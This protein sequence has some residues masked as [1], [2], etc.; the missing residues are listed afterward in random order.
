MFVYQTKDLIHPLAAIARGV[1]H[2]IVI[3]FGVWNKQKYHKHHIYAAFLSLL[4]V[5]TTNKIIQYV[6][7]V[8]TD[9]FSQP[10]PW[11]GLRILCTNSL[12]SRLVNNLYFV[13]NYKTVYQIARESPL[14]P[15]IGYHKHLQILVELNIIIFGAGDP[16][17][18]MLVPVNGPAGE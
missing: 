2:A 8:Q 11:S 6:V 15:S 9:S 10:P 7:Q 1:W 3:G 4:V 13:I 14:V 16:V 18:W 12:H 5:N 17:L